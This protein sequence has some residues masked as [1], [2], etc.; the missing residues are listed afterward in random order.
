M[1]EAL[2]NAS[3]ATHPTRR[4]ATVGYFVTFISLGLILAV[5]GP[6][7]PALA[8]NTGISLG[9]AGF[10]FTARAIGALTG[11]AAASRLLD[12]LP[13]HLLMTGA[14]VAIAVLLSF[15][16]V[17]S[18]FWML[19]AVV[20]LVGGIEILLHSGGNT[21]LI[22]AYRSEVGQVMNSMHFFFALGA[23]LSPVIVAQ[24]ITLSDDVTFA[25]WILAVLM[26][27]AALWL[28]RVPSP[29][30]PATGDAEG[31]DRPDDYILVA[32]I[33]LFFALYV[34]A[35]ASFG[36]WIYSYAIALQLSS[37]VVA[38]Y[39]TSAFWGAL[40]VGRLVSIPLADRFRPR[41]VL[42]LSV[43]SAVV[44]VGVIL[45]AA[46][47][48]LVVWVATFG[49]GLSL[50]AIFPTT[51]SLAERYTTVTGSVTGWFFVGASIG[52]M[53]IPWLTGQGF[54]TIGPHAVPAAIL[55]VCIAAGLVL[56]LIVRRIL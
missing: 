23:F 38:A 56:L 36:G 2:T 31:D 55:A 30:S 45:V 41:T 14:L 50:A 3:M 28:V 27:P 5:L 34:G 11:S 51:M 44:S 35:E 47:S 20:M 26:L 15:I 48:T 52:G 17:V 37:E 7:L 8:K 43:A 53:T 4:Q 40:M 54:K 12:R 21:L 33:A 13:G 9:D 25:Y 16:P 19:A 46:G 1:L 10:L 22:W 24:I 6:T 18:H 29:A 49:V 32:L 39:L 42:L